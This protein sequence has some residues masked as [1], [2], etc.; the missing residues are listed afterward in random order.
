MIDHN[1]KFVKLKLTAL[2]ALILASLLF[3]AAIEDVGAGGPGS[4]C[5]AGHKGVVD[6]RCWHDGVGH[7]CGDGRL[8]TDKCDPYWAVCSDYTRPG[9]TTRATSIVDT[10]SATLNGHLDSTGAPTW[11]SHPGSISCQVWFEYGKNTSYGY[12]TPEQ[13]KLLAG[14]FSASISDLDDDTTYHFRAVA[15]SGVGT[16]YG[17][18]MTFTT[19]TSVSHIFD[20]GP[21]TYPSIFGTH[22]GTIT[23]N[24]TLTVSKLCTYPC[25]GTGG[26]TESIEF[27]ESDNLIANGTWNGYHGDYPNITIHN[28]TGAHYLTL[29]EDHEYNYTIRTG[30]YSLIHHTPALQT[31]NG[32]INCTE[33][34][35]ANGKRYKYGIPAIRLTHDE[36]TL[37]IGAFNIQVFGKSK[38]SKP[39]V[40]DVLGKIIRTY[41]V[42]AIQE[43][44]DKSQTALPEL[45]NTVNSDNSEYDYVVS[46][47]LGRTTSKEQYAYIY[48]TQTVELTDTPYTYPEPAGTDPFHR[49]PYIASFRGGNFDFTLVGIHTKPDPKGRMTYSEISHLTDVVDSILAM[50]P[51]ET[52]I[53]VLGDFNADGDYFD[54][55]T[56]TNLFKAPKFRWV[57][58]NE[59][60]TM[61]RTDW[62]YDR[63]VM[64]N[65]TLNH[66]YVNGS[67]AV[68]YFDTEYGISDENMVC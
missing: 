34:V 49:E 46:E 10:T 68:F 8:L 38:A 60:D 55:D 11:K 18:D 40:M 61:V 25:S 36:G 54:E 3:F 22:K 45:V 47:R 5:C 16:D 32:W 50:N 14:S 28:V 42:I 35:D 27:Y 29:I 17:S 26:H 63:M 19:E 7:R 44:R 39:E 1:Q 62:T 64:M 24:Q 21:G 65:A 52:D 23:P 33:F 66:E 6:Y 41:D 48:N 51:H 2:V 13:S 53:I 37:W 56:N 15:S 43:I 57:I 67:A 30:S 20:T 31:A 58:T 59:M 4:G 9:V 12:S